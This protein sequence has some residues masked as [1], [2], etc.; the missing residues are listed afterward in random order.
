MKNN[1]KFYEIETKTFFFDKKCSH[2]VK[3][4]VFFGHPDECKKKK[5]SKS[6]T[7]ILSK[8]VPK[9]TGYQIKI[10]SSKK[11]AK[12]NKGAIWTKVVQTNSKKIVIK[13]K[14]LKKGYI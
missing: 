2:N 11:K 3:K 7:I 13:N 6:L 5:S 8:A 9:V 14:K 10:Y 4:E 12:K 1:I